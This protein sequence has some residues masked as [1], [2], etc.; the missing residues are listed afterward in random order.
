VG[1]KRAVQQLPALLVVE[2]AQPE[3]LHGRPQ[4]GETDAGPVGCV[5]ERGGA[6]GGEVP[7]QQVVERVRLVDL[8]PLHP[9]LGSY[10]EVGAPALPGA[11]R[12]R[13]HELDGH[14]VPHQRRVLGP[15]RP[16]DVEELVAAARPVGERFAHGR[17][18]GV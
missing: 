4:G 2:V 10:V 17:V 14:G 8:R 18:D 3:P 7:A 6:E 5:R 11:R 16:D 9:A 13:A 1:R 15:E 12:R